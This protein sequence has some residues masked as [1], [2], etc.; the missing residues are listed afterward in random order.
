M[1]EKRKHKNI[2]IHRK[3]SLLYPNH[4]ANKKPLRP[5]SSN[6]TCRS[7]VYRPL[8]PRSTRDKAS[9]NAPDPNL[10]QLAPGSKPFGPLVST[11]DGATAPLTLSLKQLAPGYQP[12]GPL[13]STG[14]RAPSKKDKPGDFVICL[15]FL[16]ALYSK[17]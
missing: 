14:D 16:C 3:I 6:R 12:F 1:Q 17:I 15:Y 5:T 8:A 4:G 2:P 7:D 11:R 13:A 10:K 9:N